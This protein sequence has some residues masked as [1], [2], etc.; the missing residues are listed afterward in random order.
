[1]PPSSITQAMTGC[2]VPLT[3]KV[4]LEQ[5]A[6]TDAAAAATPAAPSTRA[7]ARDG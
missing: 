4:P 5:A 1:M 7:I 2:D 3:G 6:T